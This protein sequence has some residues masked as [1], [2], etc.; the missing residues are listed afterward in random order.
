MVSDQQ[1][2]HFSD[3]RD[4]S[5]PHSGGVASNLFAD[6]LD[7]TYG[8]SA[9]NIKKAA[10]KE[11]VLAQLSRATHDAVAGSLGSTSDFGSEAGEKQKNKALEG[12]KQ[13][14]RVAEAAAVAAAFRPEASREIQ[15]EAPG[16]TVDT[17]REHLPA[18]RVA[19][20]RQGDLAHVEFSPVALDGHG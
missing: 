2:G 17:T 10:P 13:S 9:Y 3:A 14:D 8:P 20:D 19:V 11:G 16:N 5:A 7:S 4:H 18:G 6:I 15:R 1:A 12:G